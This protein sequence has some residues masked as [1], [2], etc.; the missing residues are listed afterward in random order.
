MLGAQKAIVLYV[1][2]LRLRREWSGMGKSLAMPSLSKRDSQHT[3]IYSVIN[4]KLTCSHFRLSQDER[5]FLVARSRSTAFLSLK[6]VFSVGGAFLF[7]SSWVRAMLNFSL[8]APNTR[9]ETLPHRPL[10]SK[11]RD[12]FRSGI[13]WNCGSIFHFS[14]LHSVQL[15]NFAIQNF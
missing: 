6:S 3:G 9:A 14:P 2:G 4:G 10:Q 1:S 8:P 13:G 15:S 7:K 12:G 5:N 11:R